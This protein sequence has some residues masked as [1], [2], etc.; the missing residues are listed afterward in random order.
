MKEMAN[1]D[2]IN[3]ERVQYFNLLEFV[4]KIKLNDNVLYHMEETGLNFE[5]YLNTLFNYCNADNYSIVLYLLD[6]ASKELKQSSLLENKN[7]H[8]T[9]AVDNTLFFDKLSI[10]KS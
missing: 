5:K 8:E 2:W 1:K 9:Y 7:S 10:S 4:S 6:L 3:E